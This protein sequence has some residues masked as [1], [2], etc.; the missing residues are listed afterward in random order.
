M[1]KLTLILLFICTLTPLKKVFAQQNNDNIIY[2]KKCFSAGNYELSSKIGKKILLTNKKNLST[3]EQIRLLHQ[4][5]LAHSYVGGL[6]SARDFISNFNDH[7]SS[8]LFNKYVQ[9]YKGTLSIN[10]GHTKKAKSIFQKLLNENDP[11]F[12]HDSIKAKIY[13]NLSV[14][15]S[16]EEKRKIQLEYMTR[17][18]ELEK[19]LIETYPNYLNFNLSTEVYAVTLYDR[20]KQF[21]KANQVFK[22]ALSLPFNKD[23]SAINHSLYSVYADFLIDI[24]YVHKSQYY[25][26]ILEDFYINQSPYFKTDLAKLYLNLTI[27]FANQN[28]FTNAILYANRTLSII[29]LNKE[30]L[31]TRYNS[32]NRLSS[33]YYTLGQNEKSIYYM[34][35]FI[36]ECKGINQHQLAIAYTSAS[37]RLAQQYKDELAYSYLDSAK[38]LYYNTLNLPLSVNFENNLAWGYLRLEQYNQSLFHYDR[39]TSIMYENGNYTTYAI[40]DNMYEK[41]YCHLKLKHYN[42]AKTLLSKANSAML[43]KYPHLLD[44]R[45][46]G[47]SSRFGQLYRKINIALA[48]CL[49]EQYENSNN[50]EFLNETLTYIDRADKALE[51]LRSR[52]NFDRDRLVTG[53][54]FYDFT[55]LSTKVAFALYNKTQ[56]DK[57]LQKAFEYVQKGKS[58]ALLQGISDKK[59]KLNSGVPIELINKLNHAKERFDFYEQRYANQLFEE[60]NDSLL[61]AQLGENMS[62]KMAKID[63]IN[64]VIANSYPDYKKLKN[65]GQYTDI[66]EIQNKLNT[67]QVVIDYYLT[68]KELFRFAISKTRYHCDIIVLDDSFKGNLNLVLKELSSPFIGQKAV[69]PIQ[70][71]AAS[72][73]YLYKVLLEDL[74]E[75]TNGKEL[76]IVPHAKLSYLPFETLLT[77][78]YSLKKPCFKDY[79]WLIK[80]QSITYSYNTALLPRFEKKPSTF[81]QVLAFAPQYTGATSVDLINLSDNIA[82]DTVLSPLKG[83]IKEIE[84]IDQHFKLDAYTGAKASKKNFIASLQEN[85]ILHLAMHSLNDERQPFNSQMVFASSDS[86]NGNFK[87]KEIYNY[88]I[89]SPL[90]VLSSCST[91]SGQGIKGEGLLSIARAFTYAGVESQVMTLWPVNDESGADLIGR[92]Y[93]HLKSGK[94]KDDALRQSK[95]DFIGAAGSIKSHPYYWGNYVL[96]GST[97]P[98]KQKTP[99]GIFIYLLAFAVLSVLL[100]YLYD[101]RKRY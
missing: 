95:L 2:F 34:N 32:L 93:Q 28:N 84:A 82:L 99:K 36:E 58:Y 16:H 71:Y 8:D 62:N 59:Y 90:T 67:K 92:F 9:L 13:H 29:P 41:A 61:L 77:E 68:D 21:E 81:H 100:L 31:N 17:S 50:F 57:H 15:Y 26:K 96:S 89:T 10:S 48:Q 6:S 37:N 23:I 63:S 54:S 5:L 12:L 42:E 19:K 75:L 74:S 35:K 24:G 60:E 55:L 38:H 27:H 3:D 87:A 39:V 51:Y 91:G 46:N 65:E 97:S 72:A 53:E 69:E 4:T 78:D 14:I 30:T 88:V 94:R 49:Y 25:F 18:Y 33:I 56:E 1:N 45:S 70:A 80:K 43:N 83:T 98:L 85:D 47:Q 7:N 22:E 40:W 86:T 11:I 66:N 76:I 52:Q 20:Y 64:E 44:I 79:P 101:R 73:H